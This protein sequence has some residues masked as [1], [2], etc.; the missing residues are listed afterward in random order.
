MEP[1]ILRLRAVAVVLAVSA[2]TASPARA[3]E[4]DG[5]PPPKPRPTPGETRSFRPTLGA[6]LGYGRPTGSAEDNRRLPNAAPWGFSPG[7]ELRLPIHRHVSLEAFGTLGSYTGGTTICPGCGVSTAL[8]G[9]GAVYH[10]LDGGVLDPWVSAG[11]G[12]RAA[13]VTYDGGNVF[14]YS[15]LEPVRIAAGMDRY[16]LPQLGLGVYADF[17]FGQFSGRDPGPFRQ[18]RLGTVHTFFS[19]GIRGVLSPL[20][21]F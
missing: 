10:L 7:L 2:M 21:S 20:A 6:H 14:T 5:E 3:D 15:G 9:G 19:I 18:D 12:Y 1:L 16:V 8:I 13:K 11:L 4:G 17:S